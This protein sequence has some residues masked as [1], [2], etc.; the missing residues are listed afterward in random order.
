ME[1]KTYYQ[2]NGWTS[3]YVYFFGVLISCASF[4]SYRD[5]DNWAY[6][7]CQGIDTHAV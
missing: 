3:I 4:R 2:G 7:L 6:E 1:T 5:A